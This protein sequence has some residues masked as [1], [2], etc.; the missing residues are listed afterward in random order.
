MAGVFHFYLVAISHGLAAVALVA[1]AIHSFR[2]GKWLPRTPLDLP[3]AAFL[4]VG[5]ASALLS[6]DRRLSLENWLHL[7]LFVFVYY[8]AVQL[9]LDWKSPLPLVKALV[10]NGAVVVMVAAVE[11]LVSY[12]QL[13]RPSLMDYLQ[14]LSMRRWGSILNNANPLAWFMVIQIALALSQF[15]RVSS[16]WTRAN[17]LLMAAGAAGVLTTTFS[18]SGM[19]ALVVALIILG[20]PQVAPR[21]M[22]RR[23]KLRPA[24][25][26]WISAAAGVGMVILGGAS[27]VMLDLRPS[28]VEIRWNLWLA[29]GAMVVERPFLGGGPGTFGYSLHQLS[30]PYVEAKRLFFNTAHNVYLNLAAE[31]GVLSLATGLWA[32]VAT[33]V[34]AWRGWKILG[35]GGKWTLAGALAGWV[36]LM[37][38]GLFDVLWAYP[39]N[40]LYMALLTAILVLPLSREGITLGGWARSM[41]L[42][43]AASCVM[44]LGWLDSA[45]HFQHMGVEAA[46]RGEWEKSVGYLDLAIAVD[47]FFDAY[48]LHRGKA[49]G[50]LGLEMESAEYLREALGE[51]R[52]EMK[53]AADVSPHRDAAAWLALAAGDIEEALV[54]MSKAADLTP[55]E[56]SYHLGLGYLREAAGDDEGAIE[57]Y[58]RAVLLSPSLRRS[59]FWRT[60]VL[61]QELRSQWPQGTAKSIYN[62]EGEDAYRRGDLQKAVASYEMDLGV[63]CPGKM[64]KSYTTRH[65]YHREDIGVDFRPYVIRCAPRDD[66]VPQYVHMADAYRRLGQEAE[67]EAIEDWLDHFYGDALQGDSLIR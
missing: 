60:S 23:R 31:G 44:V 38:A 36:G 34:A 48:G 9:M 40:T 20:L 42:V 32:A 19:V 22:A 10:M 43:L 15:R 65:V 54:H 18:R 51:Y 1:W 66:L 37:V 57:A 28:T 17:L 45:H 52:A 16:R 30:I 2:R 7:S 61:R 33:A 64:L 46:R 58:E 50:S 67:A 63:P 13:G 11:L 53:R 3:L 4:V 35:D 56:P 8:L 47:P 14:W 59:G 21:W 29:A 49:L 6:V 39:F 26:G 25:R 41:P 24:A 27:M 55:Q 62:T 12:V 5:L